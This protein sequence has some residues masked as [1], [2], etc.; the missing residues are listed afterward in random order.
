[1]KETWQGEDSNLI[2]RTRYNS[3]FWIHIQNYSKF[4]R[5]VVSLFLTDQVCPQRWFRSLF[6][7]ILFIS[8]YFQQKTLRAC[9]EWFSGS[10]QKNPIRNLLFLSATPLRYRSLASYI[11][12]VALIARVIALP[13]A[14]QN[15]GLPFVTS[16]I[17]IY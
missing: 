4:L 13:S 7:G 5:F 15:T 11:E 8:Y 17:L 6:L 2:K 16:Q 12:R 3:T 14:R 9:W 10:E 1:M